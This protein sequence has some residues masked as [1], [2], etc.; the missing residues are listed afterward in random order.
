M[1]SLVNANKIIWPSY[2]FPYKIKKKWLS[3]I[4]IDVGCGVTHPCLTLTVSRMAI[5]YRTRHRKTLK[6]IKQL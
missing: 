5:S 3:Y 1:G 4:L 6:I 2:T